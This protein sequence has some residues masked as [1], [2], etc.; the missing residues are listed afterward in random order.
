MKKIEKE[1]DKYRLAVI[2]QM[3][4]LATAGFGLV[5][6][7]AWNQLIRTFIEDYIKPALGVGSGIISMAIYALTITILAVLVTLQLSRLAETLEQKQEQEKSQ[8]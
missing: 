1:F 6:A 5:A 2:K 3:V 4:Q 7:L 8:K